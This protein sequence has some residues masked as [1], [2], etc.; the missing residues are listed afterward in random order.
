MSNRYVINDGICRAKDPANCTHPNCPN[1][2]L[3]AYNNAVDENVMDFI[4]EVRTKEQKGSSL[5][6]VAEIS[7]TQAEAMQELNGVDYTGYSVC[8]TGDAVAHIDK[9]HG[10]NGTADNSMADDKDLARIGW[11]VDNFDK[12][13]PGNR[14]TRKYKSSDNT[15]ADIFV[16]SKNINGRYHVAIASPVTSKKTLYIVSAYRNKK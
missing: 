8:L 7:S 14:K 2:V 13:E 3:V 6:E 1:G 11:V 10:K 5:I 9:R 15:L 16:F 4:N 12:V